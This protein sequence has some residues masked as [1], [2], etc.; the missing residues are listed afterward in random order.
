MEYKNGS[1]LKKLN[2]LMEL[3]KW[4]KNQKVLLCI[5]VWSCIQQ[6]EQQAHRNIIVDAV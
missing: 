1:K 3:Q 4:I 6:S 5:T 2:K